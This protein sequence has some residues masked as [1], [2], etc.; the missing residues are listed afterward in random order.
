MVELGGLNRLR[1][2]VFRG[3]SGPQ[4]LDRAAVGQHQVFKAY[5]TVGND[6]VSLEDWC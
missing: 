2:A 6:P 3:T 5:S 1:S 4:K